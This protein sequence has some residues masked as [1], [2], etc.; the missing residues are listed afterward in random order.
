MF[1]VRARHV[2]VVGMEVSARFLDSAHRVPP[3]PR[4]LVLC[5]SGKGSVMNVVA[6][7]IL[8]GLPVESEVKA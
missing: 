1:G 6:W 7:V 4:F 3:S 5:V 8:A 2:Y